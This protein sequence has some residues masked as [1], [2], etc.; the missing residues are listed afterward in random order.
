MCGTLAV[1]RGKKEQYTQ[2]GHHPEKTLAG[3]LA[4]E[5][6]IFFL[7][8]ILSFVSIYPQNHLEK[9]N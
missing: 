5:I 9:Y 1:C 7:L 2:W 6:E 8:F 3:G 4:T